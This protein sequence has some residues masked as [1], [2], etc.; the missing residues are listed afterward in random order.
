MRFKKYEGY[1][2]ISPWIL[3][4]ILLTVAPLIFAFYIGLTEWDTF[5]APKFVGLQN[6]SDL[7]RDEDFVN[8][9]WI[10]IRFAIISVPLGIAT[11]ILI[12][13][14]V[15]SKLKGMAFFRTALYMPAVVSGIAI[16]LLWKWMLDKD[17]G[18]I[19]LI[20]SKL[21]IPEQGWLTDPH[22]V[23]YS[24]L[25]M[26]V[27]GA[28]GGML[29]YLAGLQDIPGHLYEAAEIDGANAFQK[30]RHITLTMLSP[31]IFYNLIMGIVGAMRKFG[32]AYIIGGAGNQ[33]R[34]YM[35]YLYENAFKFFKMG[36]ATA[37]AWV[38]FVLIMLLTMAAFKSSSAWVYYESEVNTRPKRKRG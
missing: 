28:G 37:M 19:N 12:A 22:M 25:M 7:F 16:S 17:F 29:T 20:L 15:N 4:F 21:G 27:W 38:L 31:V 6:Y 3:G 35:V 2:Y 24:Y 13:V 33:G 14:L 9:L 30:F 32:D 34:F 23:L 26:V 11:S 8:A 36:Y 18:M 5:N 10:T 1:L